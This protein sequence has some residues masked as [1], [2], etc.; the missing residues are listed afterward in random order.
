MMIMIVKTHGSQVYFPVV[1]G[2][3]REG[4]EESD[5]RPTQRH[6]VPGDVSKERTWH[7]R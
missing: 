6:I 1:E 2:K 7:S 4:G 3:K 5:E